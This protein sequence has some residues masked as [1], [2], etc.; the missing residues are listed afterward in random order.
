MAPFGASR[1]GLMSVAEDDIPD[2]GN[3]QTNYDI[4]SETGYNDGN[5]VKPIQDFETTTDLDTGTGPTYKPSAFN[6]NP[7]ARFDET[8]D[9]LS[10]SGSVSEFNYIHDGTGGTI[11]ILVN[12]YTLDGSTRVFLDNNDIS[13]ESGFYVISINEDE[14]RVEISNGTDRIVDEGVAN[15][16]SNLIG[17]TLKEGETDEY[18]VFDENGDIAS[19]SLSGTPSDSDASADLH[20]NERVSGGDYAG[21]DFAQVLSYSAY[22]QSSTRT[23][24]VSY[25][26]N[27]WGL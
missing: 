24:V 9:A 8:D 5:T 2:S 11:Y 16:T 1:A 20:V 17:L 26:S 3:L 27:R 25:L 4:Q 12:D 6:S 14:I 18:V 22:H 10:A 19:G 7:I 23:D 15:F 21:F 13:P